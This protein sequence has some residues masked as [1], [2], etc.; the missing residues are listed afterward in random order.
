MPTKKHNKKA[1]YT[2]KKAPW[3]CAWFL[4]ILPGARVGHRAPCSLTSQISLIV[5]VARTT[6]I[7]AIAVV[8]LIVALIAALIALA[9]IF[10]C[11]VCL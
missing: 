8:A 10:E 3:Y 4:K 1:P 2:L 6:L 5:V 7:I 9:Q 11:E